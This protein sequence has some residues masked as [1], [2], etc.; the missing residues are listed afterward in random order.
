VSH[1]SDACLKV[2][3]RAVNSQVIFILFSLLRTIHLPNVSGTGN[4]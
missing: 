2:W 3:V 4:T 1:E